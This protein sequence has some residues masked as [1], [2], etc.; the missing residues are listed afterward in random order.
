MTLE[1]DA[2]LQ[3]LYRDV[4]IDY[5]RSTAHKGVAE[6]ANLRGR[7]ANPIC[8]DE[9]ELTAAVEDGRLSKVRFSG[10]GC[11]ISQAS[12]AMMAEA[13]EGKTLEEARKLAG[14]FKAF[15]LEGAPAAALPEE[16]D[17]VRSLDGVRRFPV[18]IKCSL[19]AWNVL[20]QAL[21]ER[22]S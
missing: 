14:A 20:I 5:F 15:M 12:S 21:E 13:L 10:H 2:E 22:Q 1:G 16:L 18:R 7:G 11:V 19:L 8:G 4:L 9:V 3:D 6:P 17:E